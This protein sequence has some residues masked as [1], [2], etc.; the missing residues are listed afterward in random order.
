[1]IA[2]TSFLTIKDPVHILVVHEFK[3]ISARAKVTSAGPALTPSCK[4]E[5]NRANLFAMCLQVAN[6]LLSG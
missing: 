4:S 1:M 6:G 2:L 5:Q 3:S